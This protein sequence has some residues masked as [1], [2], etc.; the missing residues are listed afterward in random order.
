VLTHFLALLGFAFFDGAVDVR[1]KRSTFADQRERKADP[2]TVGLYA[3]AFS[4]PSYNWAHVR[5]STLFRGR[6]AGARRAGADRIAV[7]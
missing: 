7:E 4:S 6:V 1:R 3:G 2:R 5:G